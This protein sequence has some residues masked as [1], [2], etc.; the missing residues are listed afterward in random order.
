M[1]GYDNYF[2]GF[3]AV[4]QC[5]WHSYEQIPLSTIYNRVPFYIMAGCA[6]VVAKDV[7]YYG[8]GS[9]LTLWWWLNDKKQLF[10]CKFNYIHILLYLVKNFIHEKLR[11]TEPGN[12]LIKRALVSQPSTLVV[13]R[14]SNISHYLNLST[15]LPTSVLAII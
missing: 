7:F 14:D 11:Y 10:W 1:D 13:A 2:H 4:F 8:N 9:I 15:Y 6:F 3:R 12:F 5:M